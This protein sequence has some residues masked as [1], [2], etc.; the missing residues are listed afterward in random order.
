MVFLFLKVKLSFFYL[1][2]FFYLKTEMNKI[3]RVKYKNMLFGR[4][5]KKQIFK[6]AVKY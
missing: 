6:K 5:K 4:A 2:F 1:S 3:I